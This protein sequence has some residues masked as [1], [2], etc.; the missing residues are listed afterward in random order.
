MEAGS[1]LDLVNMTTAIAWDVV[2]LEREV[3]DGYVFEVHYTVDAR[4][5]VYS[6]GVYGS[7]GLERPTE[8]IPFAELNAE[9]V[10]AWVRDKL[11]AEKVH[12]IEAALQKQIDEQRAPT[13]A[14]GLPWQ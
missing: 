5:G 6:A 3:C 13:K 9:L 12:E 8:L 2:Q 10:V 11:T 4:D 1:T 7:L 14:V